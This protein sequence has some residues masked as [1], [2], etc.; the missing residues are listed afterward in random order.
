MHFNWTATGPELLLRSLLDCSSYWSPTRLLLD[1]CLAS[2]GLPL[3]LYWT[4][5][6]P[7]LDPYWT[8]TGPLLH[9]DWTSTGPSVDLYWTLLSAHRGVYLTFPSTGTLLYFYWT[10]TGPLLSHKATIHVTLPLGVG[11]TPTGRLMDFC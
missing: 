4:Y 8:S 5:T 9:F 1:S 3:D 10:S 2:V 7:L 11:W 6:G